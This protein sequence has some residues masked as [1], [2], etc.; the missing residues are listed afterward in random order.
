MAH[1]FLLAMGLSAAALSVTDLADAKLQ[2]ASGPA[3]TFTAVGPAGL[4]IEGKSSE[5]SVVDDA[6][7]VAITVPLANLKT[8]I[9]LR[10][11]HMREKYL[12]VQKYP[13]ADLQVTRASLKFPADGAESNGDAQGVMKIHGQSR[14]VTFHYSAKRG[15]TKLDVSGT[16]N[17]NINDFGIQVPSYLGVTVK[18]EIQVAVRFNTSDG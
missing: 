2:G 1:K 18:P 5:L 14:P 12:E 10:D 6:T 4:K 11:K 9:D 8:G 7:N 15:G 13:N 3:V 17:L 16:V